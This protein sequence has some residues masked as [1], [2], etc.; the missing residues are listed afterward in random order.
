MKENLIS[1][2][3]IIDRFST[4]FHSARLCVT[5]REIESQTMTSDMSFTSKLSDTS[6]LQIAAYS[7]PNGA[8]PSRLL[9]PISEHSIEIQT[10]SLPIDKIRL[11]SNENTAEVPSNEP[12]NSVDPSISVLLSKFHHYK[13][14][15]QK[16]RTFFHSIDEHLNEL[17]KIIDQL[18]SDRTLSDL[19]EPIPTRLIQIRV[20]IDQIDRFLNSSIIEKIHREVFFF[21]QKSFFFNFVF[22]FFFNI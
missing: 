1:I 21:I 6:N 3:S 9:S 11:D 7:T 15:F 14:N 18:E 16:L 5:Y 22:V 12:Q 2:K 17:K 19:I 10:I 8:T 13:S 4:F 20:K